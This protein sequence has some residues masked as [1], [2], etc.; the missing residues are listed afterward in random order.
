MANQGS[1]TLRFRFGS[2]GLVRVQSLV[3]GPMRG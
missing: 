3:P 2:I 1:V